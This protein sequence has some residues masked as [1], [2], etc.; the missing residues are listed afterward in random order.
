[1]IID[2]LKSILVVHKHEMMLGDER[3]CKTSITYIF[4]NKFALTIK[5]PNVS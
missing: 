4:K 2:R 1:M 5:Q 3:G